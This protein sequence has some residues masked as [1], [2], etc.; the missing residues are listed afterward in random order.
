MREARCG[1]PPSALATR[2]PRAACREPRC[3]RA[4]A[5][6]GDGTRLARC[7]KVYVPLVDR[8]AS[9]RPYAFVFELAVS[10]EGD[11]TLRLIAYGERHPAPATRCVYERAHKR[12]HGRYPDQ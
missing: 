7:L 11:V 12:L 10:G 1:R 2:S 3:A 4:D 6:G 5:E 8:P 9:E